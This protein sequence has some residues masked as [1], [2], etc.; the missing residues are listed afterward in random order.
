[1][2]PKL[3][4]DFPLQFRVIASLRPKTAG[5]YIGDPLQSRTGASRQRP[6]PGSPPMHG[7]ASFGRDVVQAGGG[8]CLTNCPTIVVDDHGHGQTDMP[9]KPSVREAPQHRSDDHARQDFLDFASPPRTNRLHVDVSSACLAIVSVG[10]SIAL[11]AEACERS[12]LLSH[13][14][15]GHRCGSGQRA[16]QWRARRRSGWRPIHTTN[17]L[18]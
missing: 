7:P 6:S 3:R 12:R 10:I 13:D 18:Q 2:T 17:A 1:V 9:G 14:V 15:A 11:P 4:T 16:P 8:A 5:P